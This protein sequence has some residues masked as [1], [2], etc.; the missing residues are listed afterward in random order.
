M[1][2]RTR[3]REVNKMIFN[4]LVIVRGGGD[5]ASGTIHKLHRCGFRVLVLE[6]PK[7][8][9]IRRKV[10]FSEAVYDGEVTIEGVTAVLAGSMN[11]IEKAW[12]ENKIPVAIDPEG[13]WIKK[14]IP[15]VLVDAMIAKRNLGT[16][17]DMADIVIGLG[18]GFIAGKDVDVVIET[19]RGHNL[20]RLIFEGEAEKNTGVPGDIE[21]YSS[22]RV[23]H[24]P[25]EGIIENIKDIGA[26]VEK[27]E[28]IARVGNALIRAKIPG[29]LRGI[30]RDG[31]YVK[32]G[33]KIADVD[34]RLTEKANCFTISDKARNIAGGVLE[35]I[36]YMM[37]DEL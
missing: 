24:S 2:I 29:V 22:E 23:I 13:E 11:E 20:G 19:V 3:N 1:Y 8:T 14:L 6:L 35:A 18:P 33:L 16:T 37:K 4:K 15:S 17:K 12:D 5:L 9:S 34:P 32:K 28:V 26:I 31:S 21:G 30:I 7:P 25:E 36:L 27:D 10:S